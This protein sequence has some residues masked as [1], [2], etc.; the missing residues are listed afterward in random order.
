MSKADF[1]LSVLVLCLIALATGGCGSSAE[2][3]SADSSSKPTPPID[4]S[5]E[6]RGEPLVGQPVQINVEA[7]SQVAL[8]DVSIEVFGDE[9]IAIAQSGFN[10]GSPRV[11][12]DEAMIRTLTVTPLVNGTLHVGVLVQADVNGVTQSRNILIPIRIGAGIAP[13]R[14]ENDVQLDTSG[15]R[16]ISLPSEESP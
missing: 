4:I 5:Y 7:R 13:E 8:T 14:P 3:V 15:E 12:R 2:P 9:R 16:I 10:R 11:P 6:L 1:S